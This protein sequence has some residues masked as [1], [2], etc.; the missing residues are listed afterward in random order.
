MHPSSSKSSLAKQLFNA[1]RKSTVTNEESEP[2]SKRKCHNNSKGDIEVID[3]E[4][5]DEDEERK[6]KL[7]DKAKEALLRESKRGAERA[8]RFGAQGWYVPTT[9]ESQLLHIK[10]ILY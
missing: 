2:D 8:G 7:R 5:E 10:F 4:V 3:V 9:I 1:K 6:K